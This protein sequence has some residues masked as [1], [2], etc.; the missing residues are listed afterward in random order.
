VRRW[1]L[2]WSVDF[3]RDDGRVE[4]D[5][6]ERFRWDQ[7]YWRFQLRRFHRLREFQWLGFRRL[8]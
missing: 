6:V 1:Q 3:E 5:W 2:L 4:C 7:Q 8:G